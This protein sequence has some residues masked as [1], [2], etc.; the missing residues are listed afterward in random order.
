MEKLKDPAML[1]SL[2]DMAAL[3]G[4][5][6]HFQ[7]KCDTLTGEVTKLTSKLDGALHKIGEL[8]QDNKQLRDLVTGLNRDIGRINDTVESLP[9]TSTIRVLT[10]D[11][12]EVTQTLLDNG[13]TVNL[14]S[15]DRRSRARLAEDEREE[16]EERPRLRARP[17]PHGR[18]P[19][20]HE[21]DLELIDQVRQHTS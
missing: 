9:T 13:M 21:D 11:L 18:R 17:Q 5:T 7:R 14:P 16:R 15:R 2:L 20:T 6:Y 4:L 12:E 8:S 1:F 19:T 3:I 10:S